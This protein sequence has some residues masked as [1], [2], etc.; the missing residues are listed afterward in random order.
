[1]TLIRTWI[2]KCKQTLIQHQKL[3][4]QIIT[5]MKKISKI[6]K[7]QK[8]INND[9]EHFFK[10]KQK[11]IPEHAQKVAKTF[12]ERDQPQSMGDDIL[13][14]IGEIKTQCESM[15]P[16]LDDK[17]QIQSHI[18]EFNSERNKVMEEEYR[19]K[20][21]NERLNQLN[22]NL[23]TDINNLN[24]EDINTKI[25][26][27][28]I[29]SFFLFLSESTFNTIAFQAFG[30]NLLFSMLLAIP[31]TLTIIVLAHIFGTQVRKIIN[32]KTKR[33]VIISVLL[34]MLPVFYILGQMR[35]V[36]LE[37]EGAS[38]IGTTA[39]IIF[40]YFFFI[41][42]AIV[43]GKY[44]PTSDQRKRYVEYK[45]L[46]AELAK[47]GKQI[48]INNDHIT[49]LNHELNKKAAA[50]N[51]I[52]FYREN[53][54]DEVIK[55]YNNAISIFIK[56]NLLYRGDRKIPDCFNKPI[57]ELNINQRFENY[58]NPPNTKES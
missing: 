1:M 54:V 12:G 2:L 45:R 20:A 49:K 53:K 33:M 30:D 38:S 13:P 3:L 31:I 19:I 35:S 55:L 18:P 32:I 47:N 29:I 6:Y 28:L 57:P 43:A 4:T 52:L 26:I 48:R 58:L 50:I 34:L 39:F 11:E 23:R 14:Y 10:G 44:W 8:Y 17:V 46:K 51:L 15:I 42:T 56:T 37:K 40:N 16:Y 24:I 27:V 5:T 22:Q 36:V 9:A 21:E 7:V 41:A 25:N